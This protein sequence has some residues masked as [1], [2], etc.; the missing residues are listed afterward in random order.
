MGKELG[1]KLEFSAE[2]EGDYKC[3][4]ALKKQKPGSNDAVCSRKTKKAKKKR[5]KKEQ[6]RKNSVFR[7]FL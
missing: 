1:E 6:K 7:I 4:R 5:K 3:R 2:T